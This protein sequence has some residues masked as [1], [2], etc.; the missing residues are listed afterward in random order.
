MSTDAL[1]ALITSC[2][3]GNREISALGAA[4]GAV[5]GRRL[6]QGLAFGL[7]TALMAATS[8]TMARAGVVG[9]LDPADLVFLRFSVAGVILLPILL[10][11]GAATLAAIGWLRGFAITL[12][13]GPIFVLM[14]P[15]SFL[16]APLSHGSILAAGTV[17]LFT[18]VLGAVLLGERLTAARLVGTCGVIVGVLLIALEGLAVDPGGD[19]WIGDLLFVGS[20]VLWTVCARLDSILSR[21]F[22]ASD[23]AS[24]LSAV[25]IARTTESGRTSARVGSP[26]RQFA[27]LSVF[28]MTDDAPFRRPVQVASRRAK[29]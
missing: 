4:S 26:K 15:S 5:L 6:R 24:T 21:K 27:G 28:T 11:E 9:G 1:A 13:A 22:D 18:M 19:S 2:R 8:F 23:A 17:T 29:W 10:R 25:I 12:A 14:Q 7:V 3:P 16:F 20:G